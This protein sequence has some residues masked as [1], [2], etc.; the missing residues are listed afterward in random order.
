MFQMFKFA[1]RGLA[2]AELRSVFVSMVTSFW[3]LGFA[4]LFT[5]PKTCCGGVTAALVVAGVGLLSLAYVWRLAHRPFRIRN[6]AA[7]AAEYRAIFFIQ[8]GQAAVPALAGIVGTF[9]AGSLCEYAIGLV[10]AMAALLVLAPSKRNIARRQEQLDA[11][12]VPVNLLRAL[13]SPPSPGS[14]P[15]SAG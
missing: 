4:L 6:A 15:A 3:L 5:A 12:G 2:L 7:V 8:L 1:R 9:Y 14:G 13:L 11:Q 10:F